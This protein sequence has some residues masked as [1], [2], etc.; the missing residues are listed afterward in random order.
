MRLLNCSVP[1]ARGENLM[2]YDLLDFYAKPVENTT[3]AFIIGFYKGQLVLARNLRRG[4]EIPGG[5]IEEG[6]SP[7]EAAIREL[8]EETGAVVK[9]V[10]PLFRS[11]LT[12]FFE[13]PEKLQVSLPSVPYGFLYRRHPA[14][15]R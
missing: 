1:W 7:K 11:T 13:K 2:T 15:K 3:A 8:R 5:H 4:I 14:D 10:R 12:C 6:E 9:Q